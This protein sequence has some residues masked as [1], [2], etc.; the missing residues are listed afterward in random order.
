MMRPERYIIPLIAIVYALYDTEPSE[1]V[2]RLILCVALLSMSLL[3]DIYRVRKYNNVNK[4]L[5]K[6]KGQIDLLLKPLGMSFSYGTAISYYVEEGNKRYRHISALTTY[7]TNEENSVF[8]ENELTRLIEL[9]NQK[10][11]RNM[12]RR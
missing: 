8:N 1:F 7:T 2:S 6:I 10:Y 3:Y 11:E 12:K 9:Y 4:D 5:A